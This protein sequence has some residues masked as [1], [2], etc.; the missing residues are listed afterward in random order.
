MSSLLISVSLLPKKS[1][2]QKSETEFKLSSSKYYSHGPELGPCVECVYLLGGEGT[3]APGLAA[4]VL[5][6]WGVEG[7]QSTVGHCNK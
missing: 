3:L 7:A 6:P 2:N 1:T 5:G 4:E